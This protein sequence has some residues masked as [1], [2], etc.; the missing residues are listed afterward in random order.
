MEAEESIKVINHI[1]F[2]VTSFLIGY[3][4]AVKYNDWY[5]KRKLKTLE[6][7]GLDQ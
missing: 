2:I 6:W 1:V 3:F 5:W 7:G 4:I